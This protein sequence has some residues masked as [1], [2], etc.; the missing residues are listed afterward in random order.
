M[1]GQMIVT[2][3]RDGIIKHKCAACG[4][5]ADIDAPAHKQIL[6]VK[7]RCGLVITYTIER[8]T[9]RRQAYQFGRA[10]C[11]LST[12]SKHTIQLTDISFGGMGFNASCAEDRFIVGK[13]ISI[14]YEL[15]R[16]VQCKHDFLVCSVKGEHVGVQYADGKDYSPQQ[17]I[18]IQ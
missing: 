3:A 14:T 9:S 13:T 12:Q 5:I 10:Q 2:N 4:Y 7:C 15:S 18:I 17:R 8:R 1:D 11:A 6:R 16:G